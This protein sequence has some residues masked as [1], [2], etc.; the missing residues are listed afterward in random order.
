MSFD[1]FKKDVETKNGSI[2]KYEL[3]EYHFEPYSFGSGRLGYRIKG[4]N[5]KFVF[6]GRD[7]RLTWLVS[8]PQKKYFEAN[9]TEIFS[10]DGLEMTVEELKNEIKDSAQ[11]FV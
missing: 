3:Q 6:D 2:T 9:F 5:H 1:D 8:G 10:K 11:H 7:N 4:K